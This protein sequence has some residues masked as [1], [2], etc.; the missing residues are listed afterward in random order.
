MGES[1]KA[2]VRRFNQQVIV[3]GDRAAF[4]TLVALDFIN[5]SAP[6]GAPRDR[7]SLWHTFDAL[8]RPAFSSLQVEIEEQVAEGDRVATRK[9][10]SGVHTGALMGVAATGLPVRIQVMDIVQIVEGQYLAHWGMNSLAAVV[11]QLREAS[12]RA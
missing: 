1:N 3:A 10:I 7:E 5:H 9:I 4:E 12:Q 11:A 8:L 6:P 2:V